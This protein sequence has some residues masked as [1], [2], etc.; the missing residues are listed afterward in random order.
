MDLELVL[1]PE[2]PL[3]NGGFIPYKN[4]EDDNLSVQELEQV[5]K[6]FK[7]DISKPVKI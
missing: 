7:I 1:D 4:T 2:K 6:H 3:T 5:A